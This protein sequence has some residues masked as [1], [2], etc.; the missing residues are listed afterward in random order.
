M[1][2]K[3]MML[4]ILLMLTASLLPG[5]GADQTVASLM[6]KIDQQ[7]LQE[8]QISDEQ[9]ENQHAIE[10]ARKMEVMVHDLTPSQLVDLIRLCWQKI[11]EIP[12]DSKHA[13]YSHYFEEVIHFSISRLGDLKTDAAKQALDSVRVIISGAASLMETWDEA[14]EKQAK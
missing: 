11:H 12:S 14:K 2:N 3:S 4:S 13:R 5:F 9:A 7:A 10:T 1:L 6:K 8:R